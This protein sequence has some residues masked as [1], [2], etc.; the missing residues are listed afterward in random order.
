MEK[1]LKQCQTLFF[2][3]SKITIDG[4]CSHEI[5]RHLL[6]GKKVMTNLESIFK[7]RDITLPTKVHHSQGY[8]FSSGHVWMLELDCEESWALWRK[9]MHWTVVLEKTLESPLDCKEI[10]PVHSEGD[11]PWD[12]FRGNDAEAET[13]VLCPSHEKCWLIGK[14]SDARRDWRQEEKGTT[15]DEMAGWH[16]QLDGC[17]FE[18]TP[19]VGDGQGGLACCDSWGRKE[20]DSTEQLNRT[21]LRHSICF[22][23][24]FYMFILCHKTLSWL[25]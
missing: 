6:L 11:Q 21:E 5:K 20:L 15:E 12:F 17:K 1:Q 10:Q 7:S 3:S 19:G 25:L 24:F 2:L 16:H 18:W 13:P 23:F 8:G 4:D 14:D 22:L 9:L